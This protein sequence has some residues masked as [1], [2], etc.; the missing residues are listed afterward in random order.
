ME[1]SAS[2]IGIGLS[3]ILLTTGHEQQLSYHTRCNISQHYDL[4]LLFLYL[5]ECSQMTC[6]FAQCC[7]TAHTDW[8][9]VVP[10]VV[11]KIRDVQLGLIYHLM[12]V[13]GPEEPL[14]G[15]QMR[16][17]NL[18]IKQYSLCLCRFHVANCILSLWPK[19]ILSLC[20]QQLC[21]T[22]L[23]STSERCCSNEWYPY[24]TSQGISFTRELPVL[25][26]LV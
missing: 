11:T 13:Q 10:N 3:N 1:S 16:K 7:K 5:F 12:F 2:H 24:Q 4:V 19:C 6:L 9:T 17:I 22:P 15:A 21:G 8:R 18:L 25:N 20:M 26:M 23:W 14:I